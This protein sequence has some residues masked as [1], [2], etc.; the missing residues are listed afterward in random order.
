MGTQL[1][2]MLQKLRDSQDFKRIMYIYIY[3]HLYLIYTYSYKYTLTGRHAQNCTL[4][5][6][7]P[8]VKSSTFLVVAGRM[9][10]ACPKLGSD[11]EMVGS[12]RNWSPSK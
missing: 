1:H 10:R 4:K 12:H 7:Y 2:G 9:T 6:K 3:I 11:P 5:V 8:V